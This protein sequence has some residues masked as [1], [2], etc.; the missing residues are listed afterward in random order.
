MTIGELRT[1]LGDYLGA[2][3]ALESAAAVSAEADLPAIELRLG[4][5]HARRGDTATAAS[6]LDGAL[7]QIDGLGQPAA[8]PRLLGAILVERS[9]VAVRAGD[10]ILANSLA[11][12]ALEVGTAN[13]DAQATGAAL[14]LIG[15][16]ARASGDLGAARVALTDS[17]ALA[18]EDTEPG[19]A[20]AA[21]NALALVEAAAGDRETAIRLLEEAL[22][23][24]RRTGELHLEAAVENNLADQLH[25][26]GRPEEAIVHLKRAVTLFA[27]V[28]GRPG[29]LE[30]EIWKLVTW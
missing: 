5:V 10:L 18:A 22:V 30:P 21:R 16:V 9:V 25:A 12:R 2:I 7:D 15:L 19:P 26:V 8:D 27:D 1:S 28:G 3:T 24:C 13:R 20:T 4:L 17:L 14:R 6:H 29:E 23:I 11:N